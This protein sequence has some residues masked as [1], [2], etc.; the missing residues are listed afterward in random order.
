M[1]SRTAENLYWISRYLERAETM[2]RLLDV[3]YRMSLFPNLKGFHSEWDSVLSAAGVKSGY[4]AKYDKIEQSKVQDYLFFDKD[5]LSSVF[6]CIL[7]ARNNA[8]V[9]RT[10]F[11]REAWLAINQTYREIIEFKNQEYS[12]SDIPKFT[13]WAIQHVNMFRGAIS[14]LLRNDGYHFLFLGSFIERADNSARLLDVKYYVLLPSST[15]VGGNLDNLQW[16]VLLRSL[17]SFRAF[18]WAYDGNITSSKIAD[19][20]ILN[21]D[22]SRSLSFCVNKIVMHLNGLRCSSEKVSDI[23]SG[24]K[25]VHESVK[26]NNIETI[27]EQGLHEYVGDFIMNINNLDQ[28]IQKQFF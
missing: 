21:N 6:N 20:F 17:S 16:T 15:Y 22:C 25:N 19:F 5:N 23:Y 12:L 24:L 14:S 26:N 2:A 4:I 10:S 28:N 8:L 9:V 1:L 11:T 18:R 27:I 3:G 7:N 13:E